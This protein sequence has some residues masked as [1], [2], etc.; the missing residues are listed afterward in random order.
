MNEGIEAMKIMV[1]IR[2]KFCLVK[3]LYS[4]YSNV[5]DDRLIKIPVIGFYL[6]VSLDILFSPQE[7]HLMESEDDVKRKFKEFMKEK[8]EETN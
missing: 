8:R 3:V 4:N 7:N 2:F 1:E 6:N 5:V